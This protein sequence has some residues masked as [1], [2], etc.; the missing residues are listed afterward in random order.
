MTFQAER[1][2]K[3]T[4][5]IIKKIIKN[6]NNNNFVLHD[7]IIKLPFLDHIANFKILQPTCLPL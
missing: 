1:R 7:Y 2:K 5:T 4:G 6:K 3:E